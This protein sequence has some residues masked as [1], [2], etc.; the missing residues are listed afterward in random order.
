MHRILDPRRVLALLALVL[1]T[2]CASTGAIG[3]L[4]VAFQRGASQP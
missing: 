1:P 2:A 4:P 3:H